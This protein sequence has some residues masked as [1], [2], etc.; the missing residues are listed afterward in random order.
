[1]S[2]NEKRIE[3]GYHSDHRKHKYKLADEQKKTTQQN[4]YTQRMSNQSNRG[5]QNNNSA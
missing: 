3:E 2:R 4:V 5:L 1:M